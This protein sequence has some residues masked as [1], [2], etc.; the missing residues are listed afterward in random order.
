MV[1]VDGFGEYEF[2]PCCRDLSCVP[3]TWIGIEGGGGGGTSVLVLQPSGDSRYEAERNEC[4][5]GFI[6]SFIVRAGC[7]R[8]SS[9]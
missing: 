7:S 2:W 4:Q 6:L 1:A 3:D 9:C 8:C 5:I